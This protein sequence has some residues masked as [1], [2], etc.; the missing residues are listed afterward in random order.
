VEKPD[1]STKLPIRL[2]SVK[3]NITTDPASIDGAVSYWPSHKLLK[4][5]G[6]QEYKDSEMPTFQNE[7]EG[8][9]F[10][11]AQRA[12][13]EVE[14]LGMWQQASSPTVRQSGGAL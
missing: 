3:T 7:N 14:F 1:L 13:A 9:I 2:E 12:E 6:K 10:S 4:N 5:S 8:C 11:K